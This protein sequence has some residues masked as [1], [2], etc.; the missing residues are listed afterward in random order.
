LLAIASSGRLG[1]QVHR[2]AKDGI[3]TPVAADAAGRRSTAGNVDGTT[4]PV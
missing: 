4:Q 3:P 2:S 1:S